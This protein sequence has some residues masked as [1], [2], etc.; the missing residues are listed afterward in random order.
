MS[1]TNVNGASQHGSSSKEFQKLL[2]KFADKTSTHRQHGFWSKE[3]QKLLHNFADKTSAHGYSKLI[4][5]QNYV[6]KIFWSVLIMICAFLL[7][8]EISKLIFLYH[9]KPV[10]TKVYISQERYLDFP[11]V[12]LCNEN[13]MKKDKK[14]EL[15]KTIID[16]LKKKYSQIKSFTNVTFEEMANR[17]RD[18]LA[19]HNFGHQFDELIQ[20]CSWKNANCTPDQWEKMLWHWKFGCCYAFNSGQNHTHNTHS[21][22]EKNILNVN[23]AGPGN[24]L[25]L[26]LYL[27]QEEYLEN[28]E[29]AGARLYIGDQGEL[30]AISS[31]GFTLAPGFAYSIGITKKQHKRI[32]KPKNIS[33]MKKDIF[34]NFSHSTWQKQITKYNQNVCQKLCLADLQKKHCQCI[35]YDLPLPSKD[36][37]VCSV[38]GNHCSH[39]L[40]EKYLSGEIECSKPCP[41]PCVQNIYETDISFS[42]Y[43]LAKQESGKNPDDFLKV[44]IYYKTLNVEVWEDREY[45]KMENLVADIGGQLGLFAGGSL[46]TLIEF[47]SLCFVIPWTLYRSQNEMDIRSV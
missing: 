11:V 26:T 45:Y 42:R 43:R 31:G 7:C 34:L 6:V 47:V 8:F 20:S 13:M 3:F 5:S 14:S 2:H 37:E 41:P 35:D 10:T 17:F 1:Q 33:C 25:R 21:I 46:L 16:L 18:N 12:L 32:Q 9:D 29:V 27:N 40:H 28:T 44:S 23:K 30:Y 36:T 39:E 4:Y 38:E 19:I 22:K 15:N 24:A